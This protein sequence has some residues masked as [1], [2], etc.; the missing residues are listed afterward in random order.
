[1]S[2]NKNTDLKTQLTVIESGLM[3]RASEF[4]AVLPA[5]CTPEKFFRVVKTAIIQNSELAFAERGSLYM[6]AYKCAQDG[7]IPDGREAAFVIFKNAVTYMPMVAGVLKKIRNSGEL[8]SISS[9]VVYE[10]DE[11]DYCLGDDEHIIHKP[12]ISERGDVLC[13][14]AIA[15][16]KDGGTYRDVMT[17]MEIERIRAIGR[18]S[19]NGSSPWVNHWGEMAK[20]TIIRRL[21]KRLPMSTDVQDVIHRDDDLYDLTGNSSNVETTK[22]TTTNTS[23]I[24]YIN[25]QVVDIGNAPEIK[26]DAAELV[27]DDLD[28]G[29]DE[30]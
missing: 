26:Q 30:E 6:S 24:D 3:E 4:N 15:K 18:S 17:K 14:Y 11:F 29:I 25:S 13:V 5:N 7:L 28:F 22:L 9:H 8:L 1:M 27:A 16:T 10:K 2:T 12:S 23:A 20:K 21:A 19:S